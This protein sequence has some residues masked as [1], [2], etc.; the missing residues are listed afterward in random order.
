MLFTAYRQNNKKTR[1]SPESHLNITDHITPL[2]IYYTAIAQQKYILTLR[3]FH[4]TFIKL[5][6]FKI[7]VL[8]KYICYKYIISINTDAKENI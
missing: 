7:R 5:F 1:D 6:F 4:W 2:S 3:V 8:L